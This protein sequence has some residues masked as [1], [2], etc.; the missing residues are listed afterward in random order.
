LTRSDKFF[1][2]P[3]DLLSK[4]KV[5]IKYNVVLLS[6]GRSLDK[7]RKIKEIVYGNVKK[8]NVKLSVNIIILEDHVKTDNFKLF[9]SEDDIFRQRD[10]RAL[11]CYMDGVGPITE[12]S[13]YRPVPR[14]AKKFKIFLNPRFHPLTSQG[15]GY[16]NSVL[17]NYMIRFGHVYTTGRKNMVDIIAKFLTFF[18][19]ND[20][21]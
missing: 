18:I 12:F 2:G 21:L 1:T 8:N 17:T 9:K 13:G 16:L 11:I 3:V 15:N 19:L 14:V 4:H 5:I 6:S 20:T 10:V 7:R